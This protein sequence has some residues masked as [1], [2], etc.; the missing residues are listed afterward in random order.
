[1]AAAEEVAPE[2][3]DV[4]VIDLRSVVPLDVETVATSVEKTGRLLVVDEDYLSFGLS[5]ELVTRVMES[6]VALSAFSRHGVPDVPIPGAW[7]LEKGV[8]P[9]RE[10]IVRAIR[11]VVAT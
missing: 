11:G 1:V 10:S 9:S 7:S 8:V 5:A 2:G 4:E 3:I 6:G